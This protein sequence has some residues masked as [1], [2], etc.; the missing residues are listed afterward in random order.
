MAKEA[1]GQ[2]VGNG[3]IGIGVWGWHHGDSNIIMCMGGLGPFF[4]PIVFNFF[5]PFIYLFLP[6]SLKKSM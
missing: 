3:S 5:S 6:A 4:L 1:W 2:E